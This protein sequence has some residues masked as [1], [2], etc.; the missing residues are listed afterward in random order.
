MATPP[1][2]AAGHPVWTAERSAAGRHSPWLVA[3]VIS[4][5]AFMEVLDTAI[6]NVALGH[7]AGATASSY[8]QATWVLTSYL[9]ANAIVIPLSGWLTEVIGRKRYYMI[10][11][12][13]F[14][15]ASLCCGL[16]PTLT[17]LILAR[18]LQGVAGGGLQPVTQAM[19]VD[20]FPPEKRGQALAM[21]GVVVII[22]PTIGPILGGT[23]TDNYSWHWIFL[24]N[25][26][27]GA[28]SLALVEWVVAEPPL[29]LKER[30]QRWQRGIRLDLTGWLLI[31]LALG[32]LE[33]TM[34]RGQREDWFASSLI[35][36]T[37][38]LSAVSFIAFVLWELCRPDP[39]LDMRLFK[40]RN[41]GL[42][43]LIIMIVG[44]ILFGTTQFLPQL[45]QEVLGYTATDAGLAM[46]LGGVVTLIVMPIA[47]MLSNKVQP[48]YLLGASLVIEAL[49]LWNM[50]RFSTGMALRDAALGRVWQMVGI[51]FLFVPLTNAAYV[52]LPPARTNQA[53]A[54]LNV[55]R[56][57]GGTIGIS[58]VQALLSNRQQMHQS[59]LVE[60]LDPL[61]LNYADTLATMTQTLTA[62][63]LSPAEASQVAVGQIYQLVQ[64][65][66]YMLAF[67]DCFYALMVFVALV[68]P[69][70]W[71]LRS[72]PVQ[73][74]PATPQGLLLRRR[75]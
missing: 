63:G 50:T 60:G 64:Q 19:L 3:T 70:V 42:A 25:V 46:T 66:A 15:F 22:A 20:T 37:A 5:S 7:I 58:M 62:Q 73:H 33:V 49:A 69:L 4:I 27:V 9:I 30:R 17:L 14:S 35:R 53:S 16:A 2:G 44:V 34:D 11:V 71:L 21:Y 57:L 24:I 52:G 6:A 29:L 41:F 1:G 74:T 43:T 75:V 68:F 32:C 51:P 8:D 18:I 54:M 45:L 48:R 12:A 65:Q 26:P 59:R 38:I 67:I 72:S 47:G 13:L 28:L 31:A 61:N 56:N 40:N 10:S 39:L 23:I 36:T 55:G